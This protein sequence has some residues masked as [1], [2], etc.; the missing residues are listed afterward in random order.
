MKIT[1]SM[2]SKCSKKDKTQTLEDI[3]G[4]DKVSG[5]QARETKKSF[6]Y[7]VFGVSECQAMC[8]VYSSLITMAQ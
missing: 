7:R 4:N 5:H 6:M 1:N 8:K 3:E 2:E